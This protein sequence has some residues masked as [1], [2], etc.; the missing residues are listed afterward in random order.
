[1]TSLLIGVQI[2]FGFAIRVL[3]A[4]SS[5]ECMVLPPRFIGVTMTYV[6]FYELYYT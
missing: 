6:L 2:N 4:R 3:S 1:M 5:L